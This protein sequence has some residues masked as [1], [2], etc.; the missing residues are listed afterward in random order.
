MSNPQLTDEQKLE[1]LCE[2]VLAT[3]RECQAVTGWRVNVEFGLYDHMEPTIASIER[4]AE[5]LGFDRREWSAHPQGGAYIIRNRDCQVAVMNGNMPH[6]PPEPDPDALSAQGE[7]DADE[8]SA[9]AEEVSGQ[10]IALGY[11]Q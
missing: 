2:K 10:I 8:M 3:V 9:E 7:L 6:L 11:A 5:L 4:A 1:Y